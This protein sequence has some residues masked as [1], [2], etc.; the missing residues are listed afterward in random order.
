MRNLI[1]NLH[2]GQNFKYESEMTVNEANIF[3]N[4]VILW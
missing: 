4:K 1:Y 3:L 2:L